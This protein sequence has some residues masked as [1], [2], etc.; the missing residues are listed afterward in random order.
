[1]SAESTKSMPKK[2]MR[3]ATVFT[4]V[5]VC[6]VAGAAAANAQD[7]T[8]AKVHPGYVRE[9]GSIREVTDCGSNTWVHVVASN[10][11]DQDSEY[12]YG[13][14][15]EIQSPPGHG[16]YYECGGENYGELI[17]Y[18]SAGNTWYDDFGP[19]RTYATVGRGSLYVVEIFSWTG[20]DKCPVEY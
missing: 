1:M 20:N 12:C 18:L 13:Y 16:A 8:H 9:Y 5:A 3:V 15:G 10:G 2:S 4:G 7:I 17:G 11:G 19:G 14:A 6:T